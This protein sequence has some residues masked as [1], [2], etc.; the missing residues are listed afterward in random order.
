MLPSL[1]INI[2]KSKQLSFQ[3]DKNTK[4]LDLSNTLTIEN[5]I[6]PTDFFDASIIYPKALNY[7]KEFSEKITSIPSLLKIT[8]NQLPIYWLTP[9]A[10]KHPIHHWGKDFFL[11]ITI[12]E[13]YKAKIEKEF[14]SITIVI[15]N[16]I[17]SF[18]QSIDVYLKKEKY[19]LP[20]S[21]SIEITSNKT[22]LKTI[23]KTFWWQVSKL[24]QYKPKTS[25]EESP[26]IFLINSINNKHHYNNI[27]LELKKIV[28]ENNQQLI[29]L[30]LFDWLQ[31]T[32]N[33]VPESFL[34]A[35]PSKKQLIKLFT[36][37]ILAYVK[38]IFLAKNN[39]QVNQVEL[40]TIFLKNELIITLNKSS[41]HFF[42]HLWLSNYFKTQSNNIHCFYADEFYEYGRT[43]SASTNNHKNI[44]TYGL[45]HGNFNELHTVYSIYNEEIK[46]GIPL[47]NHFITWGE[48][49][50]QLFLVNN[51]MPK[52][53][54]C[55]LGNPKYVGIKKVVNPKKNITN[56]L[57]CLTTK[58]CFNL[59]WEILKQTPFING[60][61][62]HIRLHPLKHISEVD[63]FNLL[64]KHPFK[65]STEQTIEDAF[66]NNDLIIT[67][68]HSTIFIDALVFNKFCIRITSR[69]WNGNS[70]F[71]GEM[72]RTISNLSDL[73]VAFNSFN[74]SSL[75]NIE[76][77][78]LIETSPNSWNTFINQLIKC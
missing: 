27:Y 17:T 20:Y 70:N 9:C 22:T 73:I 14:G 41:R 72:I 35:K 21:I 43:I 1:I 39:V 55:A 34:D 58:E 56:I 71:N 64:D 48:L 25:T 50:N 47:P 63:V 77:L 46:H 36:N 59:E 18:K 24:N 62:L 54:T 75:V 57:W 49:F 23:L 44:K 7:Y 76:N 67:S 51:S 66:G 4:I 38:I 32:N 37:Y 61:N 78:R 42:I 3:T 26:F 5:K 65:L 68:A 10:V 30:P 31:Q 2:S 40:P 45:Q 11:L 60:I 33:S 74:N 12:L 29:L 13:H 16:E 8:I 28:E 19:T 15:P 53:Y 6:S 52:N 69:F